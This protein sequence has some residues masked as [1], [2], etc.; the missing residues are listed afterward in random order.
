MKELRYTKILTQ[1]VNDITLKDE[2][3]A[4]DVKDYC[5]N[6]CILNTI[7]TLALFFLATEIN[8][9]FLQN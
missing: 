8:Y 3:L 4:I 7:T 9:K 6:N 5:R 2:P 1:E